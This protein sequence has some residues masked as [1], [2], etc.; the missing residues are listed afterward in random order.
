MFRGAGTYQGAARTCRLLAVDSRNFHAWAYRRFIADRAAV[1]AEEE[2]AYTMECVNANF[3]NFSAW[4]AR[5]VLLPAIHKQQPT[6]S[7]ADLIAA[8]SAQ[9]PSAAGSQLGQP[10]GASGM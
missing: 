1:P 3:S 10:A 5:T 9:P 7:L 2:E 4:H 6:T 8:D